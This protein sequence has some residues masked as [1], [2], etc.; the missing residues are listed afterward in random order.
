[1]LNN[2]P[3]IL[4]KKRPKKGKGVQIYPNDS[5]PRNEDE[6]GR[7]STNQ[8][9]SESRTG[10]EASQK[11]YQRKL[12][13]NESGAWK[14]MSS[15]THSSTRHVVSGRSSVLKGISRPAN[16]PPTSSS[17]NYGK[18]YTG[19]TNVKSKVSP[20]EYMEINEYLE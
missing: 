4:D 1:M 15:A 8:R 16:I 7:S 20:S 12:V 10:L 18:V 6:S 14:Q 9:G 19:E 3:R 11:G 13:V 17:V 5:A 2:S